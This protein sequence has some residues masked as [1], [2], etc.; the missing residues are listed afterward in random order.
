MVISRQMRGPGTRVGVATILLLGSWLSPA[1]RA[2]AQGTAATAAPAPGRSVPLADEFS[3][4]ETTVAIAA[5]AAGLTLL[6]AGNRFFGAPKPSMGVPDPDSV[7]ARLTRRFYQDSGDRLWHGVPDVAGIAV[8]PALPLLLYGIDTVALL[9]TGRP[10]LRE[11]ELNPHHHLLAYVE[12]A[13]WTILVS[14][15]IKY[16]VGRPRPYTEGA[17]DHPQLRQRESEDNL[18]FF[19]AHASIDFAVGAFV[20]EDVSRALRRGPLAGARPVPRFLL[21]WFLPALVG[22]GVPTL[23]GVSRVVDQQHWPSDVIVGG[24]TGALIAHLV[25]AT[26]FDDAG[27]VRGRHAL[28][29]APVVATGP[30][31]GAGSVGLGLSGRF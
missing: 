31:A 29:L 27:L 30:A 26:H 9:R 25:Y 28:S 2:A 17:L 6:A 24:L 22:Y 11:G 18:S 7:D 15:A 8:L 5:A 1:G 20:T 16:V 3:A 12:A 10:W 23:V 19:S 14:G 4:A 21:G 13:G